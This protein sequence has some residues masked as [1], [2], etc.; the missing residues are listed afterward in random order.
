MFHWDSK[1]KSPS[2]QQQ[3]RQAFG[4]FIRLFLKVK[5]WWFCLTRPVFKED[6]TCIYYLLGFKEDVGIKFM[7]AA[8]L[9]KVGHSRNPNAIVVI[10]DEWERFM[11]EQKLSDTMETVNQSYV[12]RDRLLF[13]NF[14]D[15]KAL[16]H[17]PR[18]QFDGRVMGQHYTGAYLAARQRRL[19]KDISEIILSL[20]RPKECKELYEKAKRKNLKTNV[21]RSHQRRVNSFYLKYVLV[22]KNSHPFQNVFWRTA[23]TNM[24][25]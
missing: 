10:K 4:N 11:V 3:C 22:K 1:D 23:S 8:G 2:F 25:P 15:K 18:K 5:P 16:N 6:T 14:G 12:D 13:I 21:L 9:V 20:E 19:H 7:R 17:C 24:H